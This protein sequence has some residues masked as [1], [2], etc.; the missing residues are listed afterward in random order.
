MQIMSVS[1]LNEKIKSLLEATFMHIEVEGEVA[2]VTYH[3]SGHI[4]FSIKDD[5][6]TI[7]AVMWRSSAN[8]LKFKITKGEHI[9]IKGSLGVYTPRGEYQLIAV[10][11]EPFG[12]GALAL[13]YEQLKAKLKEKGYFDQSNKK[14]LPKY[15]KSIAIVTASNSAALQDMIKVADK[16]YRDIQLTVVDT[17]VQGEGSAQEIAKAIRY[18]DS[19]NADII[20]VA[21]GGGSSED[22]W[23]FNEES[24]ADAIYEAK[25]PTVSAIGHEVDILISDFV[26]DLRAPTPSAAMEMILPDSNELLYT[27]DDIYTQMQNRIAQIIH[28][29][30]NNLYNTSK[31]LKSASIYNK[32]ERFKQ[33]F[34]QL[35]KEYKNIIEYRLNSFSILLPPLQKELKQAI[36][37]KVKQKE[38]TLNI[39]KRQI[40]TYNP[41]NRTKIGWAE[42][43]KNGKRVSLKDIDIKQTF[44]LFDGNTK[45]EAKCISKEE[46]S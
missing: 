37:V 46:L 27:L 42:V 30:E 40:D 26:A 6:S 12:K 5:S 24:V 16:R 43:T 35:E 29:K 45:I 34:E 8:K 17:L 38:S 13:A 44:N 18:A 9:I 7:K 2:S 41:K 23:A 20:V 32:I 1:S 22:L 4:Y 10:S 3:S 31:S 15:P 36:D 33:L 25:T 11:I 28:T 19:L 39:L 21:R 14:P